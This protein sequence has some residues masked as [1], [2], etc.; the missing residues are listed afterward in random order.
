MITNKVKSVGGAAVVFLG[1]LLA[2]LNV[3]DTVHWSDVQVAS[4]SAAALATVVLLCVFTA[5]IDD[6]TKLE[7]VALGG[8]ISTWLVTVFAMLN[9]LGITGF[10][11]DTVNVI[12]GFVV[13]TL[14]FAASVL[15]RLFVTPTVGLG[16]ATPIDV[17]S[18][19]K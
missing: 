16:A 11:A 8:S 6:H 17:K 1:G 9:N 18:T 13:S 4:V 5:H 12:S 19:V 7:P 15:P 2:L 3:T 14:V 10:D